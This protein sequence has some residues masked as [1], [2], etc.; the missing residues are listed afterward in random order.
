MLFIAPSEKESLEPL[1]LESPVWVRPETPVYQ[2]GDSCV[3]FRSEKQ[4]SHFCPEAQP[5]ASIGEL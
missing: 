1:T 5:N 4:V 3:S 2:A